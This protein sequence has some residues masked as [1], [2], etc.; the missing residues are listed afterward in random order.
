MRRLMTLGVALA[1]VLPAAAAA[2]G[3]PE[4]AGAGKSETAKRVAGVAGLYGPVA[5]QVCRE[6]LRPFLASDGAEQAVFHGKRRCAKK[7]L[8]N[9]W[10]LARAVLVCADRLAESETLNRR[11]LADC[12]VTVL[13]GRVDR[14]AGDKPKADEEQQAREAE[15]AKERE[16]KRKEAEALEAAFATCRE[17]AADPA[18]AEEHEDLSFVEFYAEGDD[19]D[20][21][22]ALKRCVKSKLEL[23]E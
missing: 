1:L 20:E 2:H 7:L 18:F 13:L 14:G 15:K 4:S 9:E 11:S 6:R 22:H 16:A 5:E 23:D 10:K 17:E 12:L 8:R 3:T 21:E 19:L